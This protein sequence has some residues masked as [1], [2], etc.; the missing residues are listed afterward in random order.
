MKQR[1]VVIDIETTGNAPKRGDKI[2]QIAAVVIQDGNIVDRYMSFVN[3]MQ[4][5]P[6]FIEQLT[7]ISNEMVQDAPAFEEIA[8]NIVSLLEDAY[9]VAHNVYFDLSFLQEEL[10]R[11]GYSSFTGPILDTVELSRI[12]LPTAR[13]FKLSELCDELEIQHL[14]P[15]RADS[16]AEVT[17]LLLL[18]IFIKLS[19]LPSITLQY[20]SKLSRSF[21]SDIGD[22]LEAL[23]SNKE[24]S[25][26]DSTVKSDIEIIKSL[27]LKK[28][29]L[30]QIEREQAEDVGSFK[31]FTKSLLSE[32]GSL[33]KIFPSYV[34]RSQQLQMAD[35]IMDAF[36]THQH[37]II[38]AGT[39]TGKTLAYLVS[40]IHYSL[41]NNQPVVIST[42][43]T[44]LQTQ[45]M[46]RDLPFL[47]KAIPQRFYIAMLK[48]QK[49]YLCLQKFEHSL[50]EKDDNYDF[51][52]TKAQILIWLTETET[53]DVDELNLPSGGKMLW[54]RLN[55][56]SSSNS[57][58][59]PYNNQCFYRYAR[60]KSK[61]ANIIVTN[62]AMILSHLARGQEFL[63]DFDQIIVDEAHHLERV[64]SNHLGK[65]L[66]YVSIH[67]HL[68]RLGTL[69][70][71]GLL[72]KVLNLT[73]KVNR[74]FQD[75]F[76]AME[77]ILNTFQEDCNSF[78]TSL[79]GYVLKRKKKPASN[80]VSYRF[81]T[82][83]EQNRAWDAL[84][85]LVRRLNFCLIDLKN[86][87][88]AH[89]RFLNE[90][91]DKLNRL[92]KI[93]F[94]EYC[95]VLAFFNACH[96]TFQS[97]FLQVDENIVT[98]I[99]IESKG[100]KNAVSLY[101]QP[102]SVAEYLAD[103][104]FANYNSV[105]L[106]S[107]TLTVK[108]A[109]HYLIENIGL[110]DFYPKQTLLKSPYNYKEQVK[111]L[112]PSDM[113]AINDVSTDEYIYSVVANIGTIAQI[114]MGK[115]LVLF[116]SYEMLKKTYQLLKEDETL[117]DFMIMGQGTSSG[118]RSKLTK[119]FRQFD[120]AILLGTNSF[121]EGVDFPGNE[122][123]SLIMVRLPFS[124]P[125]DP[126]L[127]AKCEVIEQKGENPF[128]YYSLPEAIL[129]FKQ[130]FGRL[131]RSESDKG[132]L[133]VFDKRITS[134]K[135]G[136]HFLTSIPEIEIQEKPMHQLTHIIE[137][138]TL[139]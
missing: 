111:L 18:H 9:F 7:G 120:K 96:D 121:W 130:G 80:R 50:L 92:D 86:S 109:F 132:L 119:N 2:I 93:S 27:A 17:A 108:G 77:V 104:F 30:P 45:M 43:T 99:E 11:C 33:T 124:S 37:A 129:R 39:G 35:E 107:A 19:K 97:L 127:S 88:S 72:T 116:T 20:L 110:T 65:R 128:Y 60:E 54:N 87:S 71:D 91:K 112:I 133:F 21:I 85:E 66:Q 58:K 36:I 1:F 16:D 68:N 49:H 48:G 137:E 4:S 5:I 73:K 56:D 57:E 131:I 75:D 14:N 40:A 123:T 76:L 117:D 126:I 100:A 82:D 90:N 32:N 114:T 31:D 95:D 13:S 125:D 44:N 105:I 28:K 34:V 23:I 61:S 79:H 25:L 29:K 70:T 6:P 102:V 122:L 134:T 101:A 15:H 41:K 84:L 74:S 47:E 98:W 8:E 78:F 62:H 113:P 115:L 10:Q 51:L 69:L 64:A 3:P 135:Y 42:Y 118:S 63:P 26:N 106:T 53:G 59:N 103:L 22:H 67:I 138:W 139:K 83:Q 136:K 46:D 24:E 81:Q 55:Y 89:L 12:T 52:L 94:E 38:E